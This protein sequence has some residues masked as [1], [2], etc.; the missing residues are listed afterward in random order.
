MI[1]F[2]F[3]TPEYFLNPLFYS[4]GFHSSCWVLGLLKDGFAFW[5]ILFFFLTF[6]L[7]TKYIG[8]GWFSTLVSS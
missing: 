2:K 7:S 5:D 1:Y 3:A 6:L 4:F 8:F